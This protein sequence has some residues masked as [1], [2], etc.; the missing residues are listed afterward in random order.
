MNMA[1]KGFVLQVLAANSRKSLEDF[2]V[3]QANRANLRI[4][5][6]LRAGKSWYVVVEGFYADK[7]SALAAMSNLPN[8]QL[9]AGPW[10]KSIVAVKLEIAAFKQQAR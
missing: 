1:D 6:S 7:D 8:S 9:K 10:P 3:G 5:R 4:Y 2:V